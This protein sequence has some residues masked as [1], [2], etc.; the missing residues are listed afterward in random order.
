VNDTK[1]DLSQVVT[2]TTA[3]G[4]VLSARYW[5]PSK[6]TD[7]TQPAYLV[8]HGFT[9]SADRGSV[10]R[11]CRRLT[12][13]GRVVLAIDFRGHGRSQGRSTLGHAEVHDLA[14]GVAFL[15]DHG[16]RT[17]AVIGWSMGGSIAL[18]YA[19]LG[20]DADAIVSISSPGYWF[21]RGTSPMRL[22]HWAVETR[23]GHVATRMATRTRLG[24]LWDEVPESPVEVVGRIAPTPLLI[25]HGE[26]DAFFPRR[27]AEVL[28]A[29]A[30]HADLWLEAD[31]GHAETSTSAA[32]IDRIDDWVRSA[33]WRSAPG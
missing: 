26:Q 18:R 7:L 25:V 22:V 3:D 8:G 20:G 24:E 6:E 12:Q 19:G 1:V 4:V 17:L 31:M 29:A 2:F 15:R 13:L 32:L 27:H 21:E 5:P 16:V 10:R 9:G 14:A 11:I 33:V 23:I 28:S 30:P